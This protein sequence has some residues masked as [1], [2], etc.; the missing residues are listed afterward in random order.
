MHGCPWRNSASDVSVTAIA[1]DLGRVDILRFAHR[2]GCPWD[3]DTKRL[4]AWL[5]EQSPG[6][7]N[8]QRYL[9]RVGY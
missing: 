5:Q 4:A 8:C 7:K 2:E 3:A 9:L 6:H 1:V